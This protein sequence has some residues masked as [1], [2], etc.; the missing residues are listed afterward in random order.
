VYDEKERIVLEYAQAASNTPV[1]ISD[2][3]KA[4]LQEHFSTEEIV[5]LAGWVALE[6]YRSRTNAGL[7]LRS[8][9]F[10]A[11]CDLAPIP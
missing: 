4:R 9:G 8:Q 10:S 1:V 6:N 2:A 7:G 3:L 11:K 5:E